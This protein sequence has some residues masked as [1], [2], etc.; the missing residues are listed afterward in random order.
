MSVGTVN[1]EHVEAKPKRLSPDESAKLQHHEAMIR[2]HLRSCLEVANSLM[3]IRND[4][5]YRETHSTF[6]AYC[7]DRWM[8]THRHVNRWIQWAEVVES[9]GP[10]GPNG[11]GAEPERLPTET[12][13]RPLSRI[14]PERRREAWDR[15]VEIAG[16]S[17]PSERIVRQAV[18]EIQ[19]QPS[20]ERDEPIDVRRGRESGI[21][22][23]DAEV[24]V[25]EEDGEEP[26]VEEVA[27]VDREL[28][29]AEWLATLPARASL[30]N[31]AR[32]WFDAEAIAYRRVSPR[33][34]QYREETRRDIVEAKRVGKHLGPWLA[35][36]DRYLRQADPSRWTACKMCDGSGRMELVGKCA[37]C[38][39]HGYHVSGL[40]VISDAD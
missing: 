25:I 20:L 35:I 30:T 39:G 15:A 12:Q 36:H 31:E 4:R 6:E 2:R 16:G 19:A 38:K 5:L 3:E 33:R 26:L 32:Q 10:S 24:V 34:R 14:E 17:Q 28:S 27:Q 22:P 1:V 37:A 11:D 13:S 8:I 7:Q 21:I 18:D 9:L 23:R 29:D 40:E